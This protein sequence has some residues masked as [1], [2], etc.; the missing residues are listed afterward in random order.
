MPRVS[1]C[2]SV[3]NQSDMFTWMVNSVRKQTFT[4]WELIV[5]DD[6]STEDIKS[7][8]DSF[9]DE[10]IRYHRFEENR[11]IPHGINWAMQHAKGE[12]IN[13]LAADE[14]LS[15]NKF[16]EQLAYLDAN[17]SIDA[18]WGLPN[19]GPIGERPTFEQYQLKA[20]NRSNEAWV[21]T[22]INLENVPI[23]GASMLCRKSV[24]DKIG[25]FDP[26]LMVFSDHEWFVRFFKDGLQGRVLP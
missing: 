1:V 18:I 3:L 19:N 5:V 4:D 13:P 23:G 11:G 14:F 25:Y 21:R 6:G 17:P 10:R 15:P 12:F 20:H 7:I 8:V 26:Q 2:C 9:S 22:L 16:E 24:F